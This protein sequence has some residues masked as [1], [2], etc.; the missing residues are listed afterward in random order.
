M[1]APQELVEVAL[2]AAAADG[3]IVILESHSAIDLRWAGNAMTTN[4]HVTELKMT[5]VSVREHAAGRSFAAAGRS[6]TSAVE[7]VEVVAEADAASLACEP[8]AEAPALIEPYGVDDDWAAAPRRTDPG[9]L[10]PLAAGLA[11]ACERWRATDRTLFGFAEQSWTTSFLGT[12]TGLRRRFDQVDGRFELTGRDD[13]RGLSTW[14]GKHATDLTQVDVEAAVEQ[15]ESDLRRPVPR[16][17]LAPGRYETI[18]PP[19]VV[20]DLMVILYGKT[21]ARD[22]DEGRSAFASL[23]DGDRIGER[24]ASLPLTLYSDP[25]EPGLE[26]PPFE[27]AIDGDPGRR[28]VLDNGEPLERTA[29]IEQGRLSDLVRTRAWAERSGGRPRPAIGNL[30]LGGGGSASVE[31]MVAATERGLLLTSLWYIRDVDLRS[32]LVTG[33]TRDG[34]YLVEDG[35]VVGAVNNFRFNESPLDL[36]GRVTEAGR[37]EHAMPRERAD[38]FRRTAMPPLRVPDFNM[39]SV[40]SAR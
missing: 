22:A 30:I 34:V 4:G 25:G 8:G 7:V 40:S 6:V 32:L 10:E 24:I 23:G 2:A 13:A 38:Q 9:D 33:L 35:A 37:T 20:A 16:I 19:P 31:E 29:W 27:L 5:V 17:E 26:C 11:R 12:S 3:C 14:W 21:S 36:L 15:V 1:S 39:A 28:S 18:L